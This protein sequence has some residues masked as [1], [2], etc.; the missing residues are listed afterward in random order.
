MGHSKQSEKLWA[1][2]RLILGLLQIFTSSM[3]FVLL[4]NLGTHPVALGAA[5]VACGFTLTSLVL[6]RGKRRHDSGDDQ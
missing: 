1:V 5:A 6:F 2:V 3:A 4:M